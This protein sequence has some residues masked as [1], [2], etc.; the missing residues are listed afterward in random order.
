MPVKSA[1]PGTRRSHRSVIR[2]PPPYGKPRNIGLAAD[3]VEVVGKLDRYITRTGY[4]IDPIVGF[5]DPNFIARL[6][7][8]KSPRRYLKFRSIFFNATE[9]R[10]ELRTVEDG[11]RQFN[12]YLRQTSHLGRNHRYAGKFHHRSPPFRKG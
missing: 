5:V 8:L 12:V 6:T 1:F 3:A 4:A 9:R 7:P 11:L 10:T 2:L